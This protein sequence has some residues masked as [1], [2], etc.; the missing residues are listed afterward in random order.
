MFEPEN[1]L[2]IVNCQTI[3]SPTQKHHLNSF[4]S[5]ISINSTKTKIRPLR[6]KKNQIRAKNCITKR[7]SVSFITD[8]KKI[9]IQKSKEIRFSS[10]KKQA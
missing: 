6:D 4:K 3:E 9:C 7:I 8:F 1:P 5:N 2:P 10:K